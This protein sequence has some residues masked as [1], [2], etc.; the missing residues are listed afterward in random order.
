MTTICGYRDPAT[1]DVWLAADTRITSEG[2][3][4]PAT[5]DSK[6]QNVGKWYFAASGQTAFDRIVERYRIGLDEA[7]D[8]ADFSFMIMTALKEMNWK[9]DDEKPGPRS[10]PLTMLVS[11]GDELWTVYGNGSFATHTDG[12]HATGTGEDFAWGAWHVIGNLKN[13]ANAIDIL[14]VCIAA[15]ARYDAYTG[16]EINIINVSEC[17]RAQKT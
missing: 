2:F 8:I 14:R 3:I 13:P 11:D 10:Y 9:P 7:D 16:G 4:F 1:G 5:P 17:L 12:F 6:I 15:A